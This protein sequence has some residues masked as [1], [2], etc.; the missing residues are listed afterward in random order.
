MV[1]MLMACMMVVL[2]RPLLRFRQTQ[3][4]VALQISMRW[5]AAQGAGPQGEGGCGRIALQGGPCAG[6]RVATQASLAAGS[7]PPVYARCMQGVRSVFERR[8]RGAP[9]SRVACPEAIKKV[10]GGALPIHS[11][12]NSAFGY[13]LIIITLHATPGA[14][15]EQGPAEGTRRE[16]PCSECFPKVYRAKWP[17]QRPIE[18]IARC[19]ASV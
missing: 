16:T 18:P 3:A 13:A 11:E 5:A 9:R 14:A 6:P 7:C 1:G 12:M 2:P 4:P 19:H 17:C 8:P 10:Q 15:Q